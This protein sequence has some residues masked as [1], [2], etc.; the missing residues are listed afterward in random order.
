M[1]S[2]IQDELTPEE[3]FNGQSPSHL[4]S[5]SSQTDQHSNIGI[6]AY[7]Q[8]AEISADHV[9]QC[10]RTLNKRQCYAYDIV[11]TWCRNKMK[12]MDS[13][14]PEEVKPINLF[15]TSGAGTGKSHLIKPSPHVR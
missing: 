14:K 11:L 13:L 7:N 5:T 6:K 8:P 4:A 9:R 10:V 3:S 1:H 2:E 12:N 15:I